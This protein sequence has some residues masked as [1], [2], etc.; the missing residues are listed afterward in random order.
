M[1]SPFNLPSDPGKEIRLREA[2]VGDALDFADIDAGHEEAATTLFLNTVQDK[3]TFYDA[4]LWTGEDR[5]FALVWYSLHT[6]QDTSNTVTYD[7][8]HCGKEHTF[9]YDLKELTADYADIKGKPERELE[10]EGQR[11]IVRPLTGVCLEKLEMERL[12]L[13]DIETRKGVKSGEFCKQ[14]AM[15]NLRSLAMRCEFL[16]LETSEKEKKILSLTVKTMERL[17]EGVGVRLTD[18]HHG[19]ASEYK[20]GKIFLVSPAHTCPE[21]AE[22]EAKTRI[23][24]PFRNCNFIPQL[25]P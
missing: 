18:M 21:K 5:R 25:Q 22:E 13:A 3:A 8:D 2:T 10:F 12:A 1:I 15:I 23:R 16:G 14:K 24:V 7:C 6:E 4:K 11:I 20:D 17:I 9:T 19:L